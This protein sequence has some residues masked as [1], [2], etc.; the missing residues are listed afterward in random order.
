MAS[1]GEEVDLGG[2]FSVLQGLEVHERVF[3]VNG[4][5]LR[6]KDEGRRSG[7]GGNGFGGDGRLVGPVHEIAGVE[8]KGEVGSG[9]DA[10]VEAAVFFY[11]CGLRC[12]VGVDAE[13]DGEVGSGGEA[14]DANAFGVDAPLGGMLAGKAHGLLRVFEVFG[15]FGEVAV[16]RNAILH[17]DTGDV[18][19]VEPGADLCAFEIVGEDLVSSAGEDD[20]CGVAVGCGVGFV[21]GEG[22]LADIGETDDLA[23]GDER[24]GGGVRVPFRAFGGAGLGRSVGPER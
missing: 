3:F 2:N 10:G 23:T 20:D 7:C 12:K 6:L 8:D 21:H 11:G 18:D 13:N 24:V 14:E 1:F 22:G 4:I 15:L 16:V 5:V 9:A 17:Q 19:G